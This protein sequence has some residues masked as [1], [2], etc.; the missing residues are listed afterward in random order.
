M[1][2]FQPAGPHPE[3][4]APAGHEVD[5]GRHLAQHRRMAERDRADQHHQPDA[6]GLPRQTGEDGEGVERRLVEMAA[7]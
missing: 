7:H 3:A 5:G 6:L 1:L 2:W 4:E